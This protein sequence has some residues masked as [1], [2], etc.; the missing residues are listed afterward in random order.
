MYDFLDAVI[1]QQ[2]SPSEAYQKFDE[3]ASRHT[4]QLRKLAKQVQEHR[5]RGD[6]EIVKKAI[7]EYEECLE[8]YLIYIRFLFG[9][10]L[11]PTF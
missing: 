10:N 9:Y 6:I 1:T 4:E 7:M 3:L 5:N 11:T 2:T 8:R